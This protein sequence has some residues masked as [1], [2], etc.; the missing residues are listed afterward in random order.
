MNA[1][2][3]FCK[4]VDIVIWD[5]TNLTAKKRKIKLS[6]FPDHKKIAV[7]FDTD[8]K[9]IEKINEERK[10]SGRSIPRNILTSMMEVIEAPTE[11]EGFEEIIIIKRSE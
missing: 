7:Y 2:I 11:K 4:D 1:A 5:Q 3:D 10:Y 8:L 9:L 6:K